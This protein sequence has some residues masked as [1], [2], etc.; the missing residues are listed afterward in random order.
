VR[1]PVGLVVVVVVV[2]SRGEMRMILVGTMS[3]DCVLLN[4]V[5]RRRVGW[6]SR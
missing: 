6:M 5:A 2:G 4:A 1:V 3:I